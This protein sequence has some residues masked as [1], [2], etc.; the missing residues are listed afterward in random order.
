M[1][2]VPAA[3][4]AA[5]QSS[6]GAQQPSVATPAKAQPALVTEEQPAP[7]T[8]E[9][10]VHGGSYVRDPATGQLRR[11]GGVEIPEVEIPEIETRQ[12]EA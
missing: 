2:T 5:K 6:T 11:V 10:P 8:E 9:Q 7:V 1:K 12:T 3:D 4:E